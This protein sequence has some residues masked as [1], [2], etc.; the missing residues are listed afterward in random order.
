[1]K[2]I[3][4][5]VPTRAI[6][7]A[8]NH[9]QSVPRLD[10]ENWWGQTNE[11]KEWWKEHFEGI[12]QDVYVHEDVG[13]H[14]DTITPADH[15]TFYM[16][17]SGTGEVQYLNS[18]NQVCVFRYDC[19]YLDPEKEMTEREALIFDDSLHHC[20]FAG[21]TLALICSIDRDSVEGIVDYEK[22]Q[23]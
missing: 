10:V 13:M 17:I 8:I 21:K 6:R 16:P 4:C 19:G 2:V 7:Q 23:V 22:N 14:V 9:V 20:A 18:E 12:V 11:I 1:M 3:L 15:V 5:N